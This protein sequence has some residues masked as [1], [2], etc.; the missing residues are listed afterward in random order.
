VQCLKIY[1]LW[2]ALKKLG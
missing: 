1:F 2:I